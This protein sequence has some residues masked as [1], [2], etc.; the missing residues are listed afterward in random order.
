M[1]QVGFTKETM[2]KVGRS[3]IC[4]TEAGL[5]EINIMRFAFLK[6]HFIQSKPQKRGA[7]ED[8][9]MKLKGG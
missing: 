8:T 1:T 5:S 3:K 6:H 4:S 7:I 2:G 9:L